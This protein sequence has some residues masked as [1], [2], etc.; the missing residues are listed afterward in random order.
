VKGKSYQ[1]HASEWFDEEKNARNKIFTVFY[2]NS[3]CPEGTGLERN[4]KRQG[5]KTGQK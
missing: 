5:D 2:L 4:I 1:S 3:D